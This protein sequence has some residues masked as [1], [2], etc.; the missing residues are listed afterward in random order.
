MSGGR[1][2]SSHWSEEVR[3][4]IMTLCITYLGWLTLLCNG[5]IDQNGYHS[6]DRDNVHI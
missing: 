3:D 5:F 1:E 6:H 2:V 4:R